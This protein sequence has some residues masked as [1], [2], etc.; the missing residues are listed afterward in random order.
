MHNQVELITI[1]E[2]IP[3]TMAIVAVIASVVSF[4]VF[5]FS[6]YRK[7][8]RRIDEKIDAKIK[9]S[10]AILADTVVVVKNLEKNTAEINATLAIL[11]DILLSQ[12]I[13]I[14]KN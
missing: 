8:D 14:D 13:K 3:H 2:M 12:Q 7:I 6:A 11:R 9:P 5:I 1:T 10:I 4:V